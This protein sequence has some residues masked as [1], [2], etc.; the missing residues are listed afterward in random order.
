MYTVFDVP[1]FCIK[2][3]TLILV[4]N[5]SI[6][7][8]KKCH[9][10]CQ[11]C[12]VLCVPSTLLYPPYRQRQKKMKSR[13]QKIIQ[14]NLNHAPKLDVRHRKR[15]LLNDKEKNCVHEYFHPH[16]DS[17]LCSVCFVEPH[18]LR[19]DLPISFFFFIQFAIFIA[20][21]LLRFCLFGYTLLFSCLLYQFRRSMPKNT[22]V[23]VKRYNN[24]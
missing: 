2:N 4:Q 8:K 9:C 5:V 10:F 3:F 22:L 23:F 1:A 12:Y 19:Y 21:V 14:F 13:R 24:R 6:K 18:F 17:V 20:T 15:K 11:L 16:T 7:L